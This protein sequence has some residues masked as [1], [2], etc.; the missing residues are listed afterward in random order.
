MFILTF[1]ADVFVGYF[2]LI[3]WHSNCY[4]VELGL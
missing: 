1:E 2:L 4:N 3:G